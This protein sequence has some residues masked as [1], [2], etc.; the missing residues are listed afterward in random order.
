MKRKTAKEILAESFREIAEAKPIDRITVKDVTENCGYSTAT[1]YRQFRDKYDLIAWAYSRDLEKILDRIAFDETSWKQTLLDAAMYY[2]V[3]REYLANLLL[4]T[5][6]YDSFI[7]NMTEINTNSL[8]RKIL[9]AAKS[10]KLSEETEMLIR[11]YCCGSVYLTC[12]WILGKY[13][14]EPSKLSEIYALS[15][16]EPLKQYLHEK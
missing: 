4:N 8:T 14:A 15:L 16:P 5:N 12:E 6:G 13:G 7:R 2:H 3:H 1:F 9:Q 10:D 11:I